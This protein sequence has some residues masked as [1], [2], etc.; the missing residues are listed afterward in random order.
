MKNITTPRTLADASFTVGH[1]LAD[2]R[3]RRI[4]WA[5]VLYAAITLGS[6]AF[7][8]VLLAWGFDHA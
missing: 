4:T 3:P 7:M 8:G 2:L 5:D 6:F 1:R